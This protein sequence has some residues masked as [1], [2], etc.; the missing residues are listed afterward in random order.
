MWAASAFLEITYNIISYHYL[1]YISDYFCTS[2]CIIY[3]HLLFPD[4]YWSWSSITSARLF[5]PSS[6]M[7]RQPTRLVCRSAEVRFA[8][9]CRDQRV[10][11]EKCRPIWLNMSV[12]NT[13]YTYIY[14]YTYLINK[15]SDSW[16]LFFNSDRS[17][18]ARL[19]AHIVS[20]GSL[21]TCSLE[22]DLKMVLFQDILLVGGFKHFLFS[23]IY[24]IILP[25]DF[26]IFQDG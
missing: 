15:L 10:W 25:I 11:K 19:S 18:G 3:Y 9:F 22:V 13:P 26:H 21:K 20:A 7:L 12:Q 17:A 16:V 14:I 24:G 4:L 6:E 1:T 23:I 8:L 5:I 2:I